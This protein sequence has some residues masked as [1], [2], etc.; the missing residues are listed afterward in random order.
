LLDFV[1]DSKA[2]DDWPLNFLAISQIASVNAP[3]AVERPIKI[4][5]DVLITSAI[6]MSVGSRVHPDTRSSGWA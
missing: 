3:P 2:E 5:F 6:D 1:V 4:V